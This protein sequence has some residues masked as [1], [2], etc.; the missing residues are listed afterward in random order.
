ME[1]NPS[2]VFNPDWATQERPLATKSLTAKMAHPLGKSPVIETEGFTLSESGAITT[3]LLD[4]YDTENKLG[5]ADGPAAKAQWL[6]WVHYSE[7]T[8]FAT[9]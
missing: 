2:H 6:Q 7:A 8:A 4:K 1:I 3:Y 5:P 9:S